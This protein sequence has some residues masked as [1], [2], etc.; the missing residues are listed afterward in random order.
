MPYMFSQAD[1]TPCILLNDQLMDVANG[2]IVNPRDRLFHGQQ[3]SPGVLRV[4]VACP[5]PS[6]EAMVPPAQPGGG[7]D[8]TPQHARRMQGL[9][10]AV[11]KKPN[12][13]GRGHPAN[14]ATRPDAANPWQDHY[15]H[16][17]WVRADP[18]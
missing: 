9:V 15:H 18:K 11:A 13:C 3:M 1:Q 6:H 8:D 2:L 7:L 4:N 17:S 12:S 16:L 14:N 10:P 5:L